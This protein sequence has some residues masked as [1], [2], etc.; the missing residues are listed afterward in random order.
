MLGPRPSSGRVSL[1]V[2]RTSPASGH[3]RHVHQGAR[4]DQVARANLDAERRRHSALGWV[5]R[6]RPTGQL[7]RSRMLVSRRS[8]RLVGTACVRWSVPVGLPRR[9]WCA[10]VRSPRRLRREAGQPPPPGRAPDPRNSRAPRRLVPNVEPPWNDTQDGK[11]LPGSA[12]GRSGR[13]CD[14][15]RVQRLGCWAVQCIHLESP[16]GRR[17]RLVA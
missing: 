15:R 16:S 1:A 2:G 6:V 9:R 5:I 7:D 8:R 10:R 17:A 14:R 11:S 4:R 12:V 13:P 3:T